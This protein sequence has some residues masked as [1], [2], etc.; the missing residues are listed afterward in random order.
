MITVCFDALGSLFSLE[1]L[2]DVVEQVLGDEL[3]S[4]G[5]GSRAVVMDWFHSAQ[6]DYTYLSIISPP[7]PPISKILTLSLP[8][9]LAFA[10]GTRPTPSHL[11]LPDLSPITDRLAALTPSPGASD[12]LNILKNAGATVLV[13]T[14]GSEQAT[15]GYIDN[16]GFQHKIDGVL[17]C[18]TVGVSKPF[19][20]VYTAAHDL[21]AKQ[22]KGKGE[23]WF[24]AAHLW[25]LAAA[26]KAGFKTGYVL[27]EQP[28]LGEGQIDEWWSIWGGKPDIV[29]QDLALV[30]HAISHEQS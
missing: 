21:C 1:P 26:K 3:R 6:R 11:P 28:P 7:P 14:N 29:G 17:S 18:D 16:A 9:A 23:R 25:D 20:Q 27:A 12:C 22:G 5:S 19:D 30:A 8:R 15:R 10:F 13:V 2:I 24:V 4:A